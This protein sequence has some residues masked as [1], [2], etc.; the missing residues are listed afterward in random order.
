MLSRW[1]VDA[2]RLVRGLRMLDRL[3]RMLW[4]WR[5]S[6][7]RRDD[8][9]FAVARGLARRF[10][11][12]F[13]FLDDFVFRLLGLLRFRR[14]FF[15]RDRNLLLLCGCDLIGFLWPLYGLRLGC[16]GLHFAFALALG[17]A[18]GRSGAHHDFDRDDF[19]A[20]A[21]EWRGFAPQSPQ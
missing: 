21:R 4:L 14:L 18:R 20:N 8:R 11:L 16:G 15:C 6:R 2:A 7:R 19:L 10:V 9:D 3:G 12:R 5:L 13:R 17:G 1:R